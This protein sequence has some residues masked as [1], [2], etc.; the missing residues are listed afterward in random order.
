MNHYSDL[1]KDRGTKKRLLTRTVGKLKAIVSKGADAQTDSVDTARRRTRQFLDE[2]NNINILIEQILLE[3]D[4]AYENNNEDE[5]V[6]TERLKDIE[7]NV[8][9]LGARES[10][11]DKLYGEWLQTFKD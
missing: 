1:K 5:P 11:V 6:S 9:E 8:A 4:T 7:K 10:E 3:N 2:I